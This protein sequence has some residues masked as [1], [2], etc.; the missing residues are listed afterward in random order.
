[1]TNMTIGYAV[2][3]HYWNG[4]HFSLDYDSIVVYATKEEATAVFA[5]NKNT[6]DMMVDVVEVEIK[7]AP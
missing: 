1:M 4:S 7:S 2:I 5:Q 3:F 6:G